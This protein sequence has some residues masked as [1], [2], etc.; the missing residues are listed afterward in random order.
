MPTNKNAI[1]RYRIIDDCLTRNDFPSIQ[2]IKEK[3]E[4]KIIKSI[5]LSMITKDIQSIKQIYNAPIYFDRQHDGYCYTEDNFSIKAFPLTEAEI[6]ALK[7]STAFLNKLKG[8][9][10]QT[11]FES[12][13]N[14]V[15]EGYRLNSLIGKSESQILQAEEPII[16]DGNNWMEVLLKAITSSTVALGILYRSYQREQKLHLF[17]PYILKEYQKRWYVIGYSHNKKIILSLALDRIV[18]IE[19]SQVT[20]YRDRSFSEEDYFKYCMGIMIPNNA[21]P[22]KVVL[23][24]NAF[25]AP[26]VLG[27]PLHKSQKLVRQTKEN[28]KI[29]LEVYISHELKQTILAYGQQVKVLK[30]ESLKKEILEI[31]KENL[32]KYED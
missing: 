7:F 32:K 21:K 18:S 20:C 19:T 31:L 29:E 2:D 11:D 8:S 9:T 28:L 6:D 15:I 4:E 14:K 23:E 10:L 26:Y 1:E 3:I 24:F 17:S 27:Q 30:P 25:Q 5:S 13:I 16:T 12:A 22:E